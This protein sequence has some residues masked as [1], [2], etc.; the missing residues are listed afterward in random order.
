MLMVD[1]KQHL[2]YHYPSKT[3]RTRPLE[4]AGEFV[5]IILKKSRDFVMMIEHTLFIF[6]FDEEDD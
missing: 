4:T 6:A 2:R 3:S 5:E 1:T